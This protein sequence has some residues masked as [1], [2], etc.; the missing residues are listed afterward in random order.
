MTDPKYK[1]FIDANQMSEQQACVLTELEKS[2]GLNLLPS[3]G[4]VTLSDGNTAIGFKDT[5]KQVEA[6]AL[7]NG[8]SVVVAQPADGITVNVPPL[9]NKLVTVHGGSEN[10]SVIVDGRPIVRQGI[11]VAPTTAH[12]EEHAKLKP[13]FPKPM[14]SL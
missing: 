1:S 12:S 11:T 9:A 2:R 7:A 4:Q 6:L 13:C 8:Q 14:S 10:K 5:P 3:G